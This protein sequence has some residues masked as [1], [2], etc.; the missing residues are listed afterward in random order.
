MTAGAGRKQLFFL[1]K[2][3]KEGKKLKN[4]SKDIAYVF[5]GQYY[6][7][8]NYYIRL[9]DYRPGYTT[10]FSTRTAKLVEIRN[11]EY[12]EIA[13]GNRLD[14][15]AA[16]VNAMISCSLFVPWN[17]NEWEVLQARRSQAVSARNQEPITNYVITP[18]MDC[19]AR[20]SYCFEK[21]VHHAPMEKETALQLVDYIS[22]HSGDAAITIHWFGGEPLL[23]PGIIDLISDGL[24]KR[25][26]KYTA[27]I[28]T[29][30]YCLTDSVIEKAISSWH[31]QS[32]QVTIDDIGEKYNAIKNYIRPCVDDP[33]ARVMCN[34]EKSLNSGLPVRIRINYDPNDIEKVQR[35]ILF[36]QERFQH[37]ALLNYH[38]QAIFSDDVASMAG[39][40][41]D[42]R[43]HPFLSVIEYELAFDKAR[44]PLPAGIEPVRF[45]PW[46]NPRVS[47]K[48]TAAVKILC[49]HMLY[50]I[51]VNCY[52]VCNDSAAIDSKG[53]IFVCQ[54]M[55]GHD[56]SAASGNIRTGIIENENL[57]HFQNT[58]IT[59]P[60]C[61]SCRLLPLC[62]GGCKFKTLSYKRN[63]SCIYIKSIPE[64]ALIHAL[65][66]MRSQIG[67]YA[68]IL[69]KG[70]A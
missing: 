35:I 66:E 38:P 24:D 25:N 65:D 59:A 54:R 16:S 28:T 20:C 60:K 5:N 3:L 57:R 18:T 6:K 11:E 68:E 61:M 47:L 51:P 29:N 33:F 14:E 27:K 13:A 53:N 7:L 12:S 10:I 22:A 58:E 48:K 63:H 55:L 46:C 70:E 40:F 30:G 1:E 2:D 8:S 34:I 32:V 19:N 45:K 31:V 26:I 9:V 56:P 43:C 69:E 52:G 37:H 4:A 36:T 23:E 39:K 41:S 64:E 49:K 44:K 15:H 17:E 42:Q 21:G 62:Q 50:P 67:S